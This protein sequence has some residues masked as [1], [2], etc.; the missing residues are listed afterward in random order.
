MTHH[1]GHVA[2]DLRSRTTILDIETP[3]DV[4]GINAA[5]HRLTIRADVVVTT[6]GDNLGRVQVE[7]RMIRADGYPGTRHAVVFVHVPGVS[8]TSLAFP[9][10]PEWV[11]TLVKDNQ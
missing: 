2:Y 8:N 11:T 9:D 4:T 10:A 5:G 6:T 7:G 3:L 1:S